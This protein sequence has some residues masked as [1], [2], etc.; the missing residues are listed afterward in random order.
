MPLLVVLMFGGLFWSRGLLSVSLIIF[1]LVSVIFYGRQG[2]HL[3]R[4]SP[5]LMGLSVLFLI[6]LITWGWSEDIFQ[7]SRNVQTKIPFLLLPFCTAAFMKIPKP[8]HRKLLMVLLI[9]AFITTLI[10]YWQFFAGKNVAEEYL[11]ASVMRVAMGDDHVRFSWLLL[12]VYIFLID[13][14]MEND[15]SFSP[16]MKRILLFAI[17]Y[18][19]LYFHVLAAK[20]GLL[21][22]YLVSFITI[23]KYGRKKLLLPASIA[24]LCIPLIAWALIPSFR[25][26]V[27]FIIWDYQ[28]YSRGNYTEGLSDAPRMLSFQAGKD[29]LRKH[30]LAGTGAGDVLQDTEQWYADHADYLKPYERLLP[31]NEILCYACAAGIFAGLAALIIFVYPFFMKD[32]RRYFSWIAFHAVALMGFMYEIGLEV[33]FGV[34]IYGFFGV[35][36]YSMIRQ[37]KLLQSGER[38]EK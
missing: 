9:F 28:N 4:R 5:W 16:A 2:W 33:Q 37:E 19:A 30:P 23:V 7:W 22:F 1:I 24:L 15:T 3:Y 14:L 34:F 18:F 8:V 32:F 17:I 20:T 11:K 31:S 25:N 29:I 10:S 27:K 21:G 36:L 12:V 26:R 13:A 35:W 38:L 6:P